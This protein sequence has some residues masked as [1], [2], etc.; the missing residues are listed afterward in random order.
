[1][2]INYSFLCDNLRALL[3]DHIE[4]SDIDQIIQTF[5][6]KDATKIAEYTNLVARDI[7]ARCS[8]LNFPQDEHEY[9]AYKPSRHLGVATRY[10][11]EISR[12]IQSGKSHY[13]TDELGWHAFG[14]VVQA[15]AGLLQHIE[16]EKEQT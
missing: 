1:M 14:A 9:G 4:F 8:T 10:L 13:T 5:E 11:E 12:A 15:L 16:N 2:A 7:R 3:P 6:A